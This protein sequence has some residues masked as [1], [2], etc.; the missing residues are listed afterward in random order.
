MRAILFPTDFSEL[1]Q[2]AF[3][4]AIHL[5]KSINA[6]LYVLHTYEA[7]V[8]SSTHAGRPESLDIA[9]QNIEFGRF[10]HFKKYTPSL[11][12]IAEEHGFDISQMIF[13]FEEGNLANTIK[14]ITEMERIHLIVMGTH[15]QSGFL[16]RA[17]GSNTVNV[18]KK[19]ITPVLAVPPHAKFNGI[20]R[21]AFSLLYREQDK[22]PLQEA[23]IM[24]GEVDAYT[25]CIHVLDNDD[26]A[27]VRS[28]TDM[29]QT[30]F[31]RYNVEFKN[32]EKV[33]GVANTITHYVLDNN[34]D[35]LAVIKRNRSYFNRLF[36]AS[37]SDNL[38]FH[39]KIPII[40]YHEQRQD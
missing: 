21:V 16:G 36:N 10:D 37:I 22:K 28:L 8:L 12:E 35:M 18:I 32:L 24:A 20:S 1:A 17:V 25:E 6:K 4:Y 5:A 9:Y 34:F 15:G 29:W 13:L 38:T 30:E 31:S 40:I 26:T 23:L 7:P 33:E 27:E 11:K 14:R 39:S 3:I 19:V 2:N